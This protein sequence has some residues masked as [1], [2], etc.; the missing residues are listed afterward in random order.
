MT[1]DA[2]PEHAT[3]DRISSDR[4]SPSGSSLLTGAEFDLA[5]SSVN[6]R[7]RL[8][9]LAV[10]SLFLAG[11]F[12]PRSANTPEGNATNLQSSPAGL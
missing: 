11:H 5:T 10:H 4:M 8:M 6:L 2:L 9:L 7:R 12:S 1:F 3:T